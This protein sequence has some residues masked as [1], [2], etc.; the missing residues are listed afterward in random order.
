MDQTT[1]PAGAFQTHVAAVASP[2]PGSRRITFAGA[3][4]ADFALP[5]GCWGPYVKLLFP[6]PDATLAWRTYSVRAFDPVRRELAVDIM[7]HAP[8]GIGARW[9][10]AARPGDPLAILGPG[11]VPVPPEPD[12]ILLAGDRTA[13]PAIAYTLER[14]PAAA[15]GLALLALDDAAERQPLAA[16]PGVEVRWV[17]GDLAAAVAAVPWPGGERAVLWAGAEA[18]AARRI[19]T[20]ARKA[21][22][23]APGCRPILNYW[24]RG[25]AEG[26]FSCLA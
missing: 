21:C 14:L 26:S 16:P 4:L 1:L 22:G 17:A 13:L 10:L 18:G 24:K 25:Q 7:L 6:R 9:A 11:A 15:R 20:H 8:H 5:P 3:A 12:W 23:L 2:T 19:R